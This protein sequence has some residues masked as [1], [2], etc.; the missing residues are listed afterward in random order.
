MGVSNLSDELEPLSD[1]EKTLL[2]DDFLSKYETTLQLHAV[3]YEAAERSHEIF[4]KSAVTLNGGALLTLLTTE[5]LNV[6]TDELWFALWF[7]AGTIAFLLGTFSRYIAKRNLMNTPLTYF[8]D[9]RSSDGKLERVK[10]NTAFLGET[11]VA[12]LFFSILAFAIGC[13]HGFVSMTGL[14]GP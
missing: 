7:V 3:R 12:F 11:S 1:D 8:P 4:S 2:W 9:P 13:G 5:R 14:A 10:H 6:K